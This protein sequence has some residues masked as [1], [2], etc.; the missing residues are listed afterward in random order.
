MADVTLTVDGKTFTFNEGDVSKV[1]ES[2]TARPENTE[3]TKSGPMGS[4]NYDFEGCTKIITISGVLTEAAST[5][6]PG[7]LITTIYSQKQWLESLANGD[8]KPITFTSTYATQS[9]LSA[10]SAT[11]PFQG[12][13]TSTK[14]MVD[15]MSFDENGGDPSKIKFSMSFRVGYA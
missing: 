13:F 15:S 12:A 4:Y 2:I 8:Q 7:Y 6:I 11:P 9:I 1:N 5:R 3:V 10:V 14:C